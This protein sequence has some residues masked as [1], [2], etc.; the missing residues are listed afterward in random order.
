MEW[1][2]PR[3]NENDLQKPIE[4]NS[5]SDVDGKTWI[6]ISCGRMEGVIK[7]FRAKGIKENIPE[8]ELHLEQK[9]KEKLGK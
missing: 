1:I 3:C 4:R 6:C 7:F 5:I 9:F 2:C 8:R